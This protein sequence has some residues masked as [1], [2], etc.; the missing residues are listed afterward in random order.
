[1]IARVRAHDA[2]VVVGAARR[3]RG[4]H[5]QLMHTGCAFQRAQPRG[6]INAKEGGEANLYL[7][8]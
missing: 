5:L 6:S 7:H 1:M 3:D 8:T 4:F 2:S